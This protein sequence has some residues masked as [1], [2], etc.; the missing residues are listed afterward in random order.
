MKKQQSGFTLIEIVA[1]IVL[2]GILAV[3]A[4]PRFVDL[5]SDARASVVSGVEGAIN[6]AAAQIYAKALIKGVE[7]SSGATVDA[8]SAGVITVDF[9]YPDVGEIV[10]IVDGI[11]DFATANGTS[12]AYFT[13][14]ATGNTTASIIATNCYVE[15]VEAASST[16]IA[17]VNTVVTGC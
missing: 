13:Q 14:V 9:G 15:Y 4:L 12:T 3:T 6:G 16:S 2:L 11:S 10:D 5:Q 1:V 17:D 8:G 7:S